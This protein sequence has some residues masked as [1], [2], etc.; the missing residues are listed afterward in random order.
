MKQLAILAGALALVLSVPARAQT[1]QAS[2]YSQGRVTASGEP[3]RPAGL[4]AAS[5]TLPFGTRLRVSYRGRSVQVRINDRGP[6]VAGRCLDL[7]AGAARAIDM[8]GVGSVSISCERK[9]DA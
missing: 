3:F 5:R 4:T 9:P 2:W 6:F 7:S 8:A 1:C